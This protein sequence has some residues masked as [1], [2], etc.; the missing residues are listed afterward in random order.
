MIS[1][2]YLCGA[3][4]YGC[5][6][7][8][9]PKVYPVL[10]QHLE[11]DTFICYC[12][13]GSEPV[14]VNCVTFGWRFWGKKGCRL[15]FGNVLFGIAAELLFKRLIQT[16]K[17]KCMFHCHLSKFLFT[18]IYECETRKITRSAWKLLR[19]FVF[20]SNRNHFVICQTFNIILSPP[21]ISS[22]RSAISMR[23]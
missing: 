10:S 4:I 14:I 5:A 23:N 9:F 2:V 3:P 7:V 17:H 18:V 1:E 8:F 16:T 12:A 13:A 20:L 11:P 22:L 15:I 21:R 19:Q 6:L